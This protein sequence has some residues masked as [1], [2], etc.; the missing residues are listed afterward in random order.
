VV[1]ERINISEE[2]LSSRNAARK[3]LVPPSNR[4]DGQQPRTQVGTQDLNQ[5]DSEVQA[6]NQPWL[7]EPNI[8]KGI[9]QD[10]SR[11][12]TEDS[13]ESDDPDD[14]ISDRLS[15][16]NDFAVNCLEALKVLEDDVS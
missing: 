16:Y 15:G 11:S 2:V 7:E 9:A 12:D 8:T 3:S 13:E 6:L 1:D 14:T 4:E 10:H 5:W